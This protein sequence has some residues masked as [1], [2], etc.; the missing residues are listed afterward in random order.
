[1]IKLNYRPEIDGLRALAVLPVIFYHAQISFFNQYY[2]KGGFIGVDIFFVI[3]GYLISS[4]IFKEIKETNNFS[5]TNFYERRARRLL[6]VLFLVMLVSMP[7]AWVYLMP[8]A[9]IELSN[10]ILST[11]F[12]GS[13]FYFWLDG[14]Q[15]ANESALLKPFLHTWSLAVEEQ[16]YIIF[17]AILVILYKILK[18][19][20]IYV[21]F[22]GFVT[23]LYLAN[24]ASQS[25]PSLNFYMLPFR[26]WE[27]LVGTILAWLEVNTGRTNNK[28]Y[29]Q[30]FPIVGIIL[31]FYSVI[32]FNDDMLHPSLYTLIPIVGTALIIWFSHKNSIVCK[33]LSTK[34]FVGI[35]VISYSLYLWHYPIMAFDRIKDFSPSE[36]DRLQWIILTFIFSIFSYYLIE[37][38]FRNKFKISRRNFISAL[39]FCLLTLLFINIYSIKTKGFLDSSATI[40]Q[41]EFINVAPMNKLKNKK[42]VICH[43]IQEIN[44]SCNFGA[45]NKKNV[46]LVGDSHL[47]SLMFELK[48]NLKDKNFSFS[49]RTQNACWYLPNFK[50]I[51]LNKKI[52]SNE[53]SLKYQANLRRELLR[54]PDSIVI[55][56]GR[57]PAYLSESLFDNSEG[58]IEVENLKFKF[59]HINNNQN[60]KEGIKGSIYELLENGNKIILLYPIPE[61]GWN[62]PN[63]LFSNISHRYVKKIKESFKKNPVTTSYEVYKNRSKE[64]FEFL[65]SIQHKNIYRVYPHNLFCDKVIKDR[66]ITHDDESIFYFDSHHMSS[67]GALM[68]NKLIMKKINKIFTP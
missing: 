23:S 31:I 19:N 39:L 24:I 8:N 66:C 1:L 47:A 35:G 27:L 54:H 21:I 2:F 59:T 41:K 25:N 9:F 7:V 33:V 52:N 42:G 53:C 44:K 49:A 65:D 61:V 18:K 50:R 55:I 3:S 22:L 17:P 28:F 16:F 14:Q 48:Q 30:I 26:G 51:E 38:P 4:L 63:K 67:S 11:I 15:Y 37:K 34:M 6:P 45:K 58:G 32:F 56:G 12:F 36:T 13:N 57:L 46:F 43:G 20:L 29:C 68:V 64:S 5:F 40:L 62:V 60:L 10:S